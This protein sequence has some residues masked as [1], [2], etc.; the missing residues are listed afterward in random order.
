MASVLNPAAHTNGDCAPLLSLTAKG[1]GGRCG[2]DARLHR[3][4]ARS[5]WDSVVIPVVASEV[6]DMS[7]RDRQAALGHVLPDSLVV[8]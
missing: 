4:V 5:L 7:S 3:V 8:L 6:T 1:M 2:N